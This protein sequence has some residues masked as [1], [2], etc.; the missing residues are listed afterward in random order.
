[1]NGERDHAMDYL[2]TIGSLV[3]GIDDDINHQDSF[4]IEQII[5]NEQ[6]SKLFIFY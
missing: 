3:I 1:M 2:H 4:D 6:Y 5:E